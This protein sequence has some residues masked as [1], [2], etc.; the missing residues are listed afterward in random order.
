[1]STGGWVIRFGRLKRSS[2]S[3]MRRRLGRF[4]LREWGT[5]GRLVGRVLMVSGRTCQRSSGRQGTVFMVGS[6]FRPVL[7]SGENRRV[8]TFAR[9]VRLLRLLRFLFR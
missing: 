8:L 9:W 7:T 1:M 5:R 4:R 3:G 6:I 2:L